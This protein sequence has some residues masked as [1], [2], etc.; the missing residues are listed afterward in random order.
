MSQLVACSPRA[1]SHVSLRLF[2]AARS[3]TLLARRRENEVDEAT[4]ACLHV[5][6][7]GDARQ[8]VYDCALEARRDTE[9]DARRRRRR[10]MID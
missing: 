5:A 6:D 7:H 4:R 3:L 2:P 8:L 1:A 9:V 10:K